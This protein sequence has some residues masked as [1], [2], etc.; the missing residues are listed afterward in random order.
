MTQKWRMTT[1]GETQHVAERNRG[2][3][4]SVSAMYTRDDHE[5]YESKI[6]QIHLE[7]FR[8]LIE[9]ATPKKSKATVW[10]SQVP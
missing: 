5:A 9:L 8:R 10:K 4:Y 1:P 2:N 6:T 7:I 3:Q